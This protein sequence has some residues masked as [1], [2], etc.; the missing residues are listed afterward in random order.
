MNM[1]TAPVSRGTGEHSLG[2]TERLVVLRQN[3]LRGVSGSTRRQR[4]GRPRL[5]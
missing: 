3:L 4:F 5:D 2:K 1:G